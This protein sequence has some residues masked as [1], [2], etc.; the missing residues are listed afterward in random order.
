MVVLLVV[1]V[2]E[3]HYAEMELYHHLVPVQPKQA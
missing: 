1:L 2:A 3:G